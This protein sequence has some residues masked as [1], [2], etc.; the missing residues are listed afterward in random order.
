[1]AYFRIHGDYL[2]SIETFLLRSRIAGPNILIRPHKNGFKR[3]RQ[4]YFG[5]E[6]STTFYF[7]IFLQNE[8]IIIEY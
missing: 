8:R 1:M 6:N 4:I 7:L 3:F 2:F 5:N